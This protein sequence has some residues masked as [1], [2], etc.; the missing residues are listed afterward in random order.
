MCAYVCV[1]VCTCAY[2]C[3]RV[4]TCVCQVVAEEA[5]QPEYVIPTQG[6]EKTHAAL[7]QVRR[8]TG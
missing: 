8:N 3:V 2:V 5:G 7:N 6:K 4:C 1:R